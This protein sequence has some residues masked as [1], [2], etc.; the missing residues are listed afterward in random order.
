MCSPATSLGVW[1]RSWLAAESAPD[2]VLDAL[3][4]WSP[5]HHVVASDS[6][7]SSMGLLD[8]LNGVRAASGPDALV[9][10]LLPVPGDVRGLPGGTAFANAAVTAGEAVVVGAPAAAGVGV[11]PERPSPDLL[12]WRLFDVVVPVAPAVESLGEAEY[13]MREAVRE[14]A[15]ALTR[16]Q[17]V[18][19]GS[20]GD[21]R[22]LVEEELSR[23]APH[24][25]PESMPLRARRVFDAAEHVAAILAVAARTPA[26]AAASASAAG[27]EEGTLRPLR[28]A[29]RA[30]RLAALNA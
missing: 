1:A 10:V 12:Q 16:L 13:A 26:T 22:A 14:A 5:Q 30:A 17:R 3:A 20:V 9:T 11:V 28:E 23:C 18:G 8:L 2:D 24:R 21:P 27:H 4:L 25:Y 7:T 29:L 19:I 6:V 15:S